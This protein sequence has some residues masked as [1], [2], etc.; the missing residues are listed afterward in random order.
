LD[1][2]ITVVS[3]VFI[4]LISWGLLDAGVLHGN[5]K[6]FWSL[7]RKMRPIMFLTNLPI[8]VLTIVAGVL[9]NT[10]VGLTWGWTSF[11][12]SD[13]S[14][15]NINM[16][17]FSVPWFAPV[18]AVLILAAMPLLTLSEERM[19]REGTQGV[20]SALIRSFFFGL[21]HMIAGISLGWALALMIPGLWLSYQYKKGGVER[22]A[23]YH[24][25]WN[26]FMIIL[27][28]VALVVSMF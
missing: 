25:A 1:I 27:L 2:V 3:V 18:F 6:K 10:G 21:L 22:S 19:F 11:L 5:Y 20:V 26:N 12:H 9:L 13:G 14:T 28:L 24:L 7:S 8:I 23:A 17:G 4:A 15:S 16:I